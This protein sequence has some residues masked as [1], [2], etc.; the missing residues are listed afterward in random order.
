MRRSPGTRVLL[1]ADWRREQDAI[2][3]IAAGARGLGLK[4]DGAEVLLDAVRRVGQ[5]Q[6]YLAPAVRRFS[7]E[8]QTRPLAGSATVTTANVLSTLST[9]EREV[10]DL[11]VRGWHNPAI[12]RE[13]CVSVK[14]VATHRTRIHRKLGCHSGA[15]LIRFAARND[16]LRRPM[17]YAPATGWGAPWW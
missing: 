13:L 8:D 2:E 1:L 12:A 9:R 6:I 17:A 16:L 15:D 7:L 11:I 14:T 3:A 4:G 5:G 10:L